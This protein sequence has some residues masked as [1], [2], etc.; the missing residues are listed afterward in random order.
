MEESGVEKGLR[1]E[2]VDKLKQEGVSDETL[3]ELNHYISDTN[4]KGQMLLDAFVELKEKYQRLYNHDEWVTNW[5][6]KATGEYP[7]FKEDGSDDDS[8]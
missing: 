3:T 1:Q 4:T 6:Y 2:L 7:Y 5:L 8:D